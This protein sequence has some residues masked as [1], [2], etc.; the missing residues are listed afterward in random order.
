MARPSEAASNQ[1]F[2]ALEEWEEQLGALDIEEL[3]L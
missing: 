2:E 1:L 3:G